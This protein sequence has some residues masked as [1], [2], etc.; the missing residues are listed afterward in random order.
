MSGL[1]RAA[2]PSARAKRAI[3]LGETGLATT[4]GITSIATIAKINLP[5]RWAIRLQ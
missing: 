1:T 3:S 5:L 2:T 4:T